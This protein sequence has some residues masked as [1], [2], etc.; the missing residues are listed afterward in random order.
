MLIVHSYSIL[1]G[2]N[3]K[4]KTH[5]FYQTLPQG[6]VRNTCLNISVPSATLWN[7][8]SASCE[9]SWKQRGSHIRKTVATD[10]TENS[11]DFL[12]DQYRSTDQHNTVSQFKNITNSWVLIWAVSMVQCVPNN[13][14]WDSC[15]SLYLL[16]HNEAMLFTFYNPEQSS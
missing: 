14:L 1:K 2:C 15:C 16:F 5:L 12:L 4:P 10:L 8:A 13:E 11:T 3:W 6:K 7:C 9:L